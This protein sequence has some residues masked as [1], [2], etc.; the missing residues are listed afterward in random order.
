MPAVQTREKDAALVVAMDDGKVNAFSPSLLGE[1]GA[2]LDRAEKS[3]ARVVVLSGREGVLSGCFD[4]SVMGRGQA[5]TEALVT[6]G[7]ELLLRLYEFPKPIVTACSGHAI[8]FGALLLLA[9]DVRVGV[10]GKFKI[11]LNEVANGMTLPVFGVELARDRLS[12]RH[13]ER[14]AL[15]SELYTPEGAQDAGFLDSVVAAE[16]LEQAALAE[17]SRLAS[18]RSGA[19]AGTKRRAHEAT[20]SRIRESLTADMAALTAAAR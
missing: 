12:K 11:G 17:A 7:A 14:A 20:A 5:E 18:L 4:L 19:Y 8:A 6:A 10:A 2:A 9:S 1:V 13:F 15:Q 3:A 16:A